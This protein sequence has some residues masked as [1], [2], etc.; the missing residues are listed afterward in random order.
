MK[1]LINLII[2]ILLVVSVGGCKPSSPTPV[3][4]TNMEY[5]I[6]ENVDM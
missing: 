1:R 2:V 4:E 5:R 6:M 3:V